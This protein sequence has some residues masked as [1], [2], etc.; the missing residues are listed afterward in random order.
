MAIQ[1]ATVVRDYLPW[2]DQ[3]FTDWYF[4]WETWYRNEMSYA[5]IEATR[6]FRG[7]RRLHLPQAWC[8]R[9]VWWRLGARY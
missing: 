9:F 3:G 8:Y 5:Q 7:M 2:P 6:L 4:D 1:P